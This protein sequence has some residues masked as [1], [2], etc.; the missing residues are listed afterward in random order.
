MANSS[1]I[2]YPTIDIKNEN[3]LRTAVLF[4]DSIRTIV[5]EGISRPYY[6]RFANELHNEGAL[7]PIVV[8]SNMDEVNAITDDIL[9]Y[10][11]DPA[12]APVLFGQSNASLGP[13]KMPQDIA[14]IVNIHPE[15]LPYLIR[16][17]FEAC[18]KR[19]LNDF[20]PVDHGF[21]SFYMTLLAKQL[22]ERLGLGL[23]TDSRQADKLIAVARR[24]CV[25]P[26]NV[27][28]NSRRIGRYYEA[29]GPRCDV[30][31][32]IAAGTV[33]DLMIGGIELPQKV[34]AKELIR[35]RK[36]HVEE[37]AALRQG[38]VQL[39]SDLPEEQSTEAF[40]QTVHDKY[41]HAVRPAIKS[42]RASLRA[43]GWEAATSGFLKAS[44]LSAA[45]T[46][47]LAALHVPTSIALLAGAGLSLTATAVSLVADRRKALEASP[48]SYLLSIEKEW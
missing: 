46:S 2:Y 10:L 36:S 14:E 20:F 34:T 8:E 3:W 33:L 48:Y 44:F 28:R 42:L 27:V 23:V 18:L 4:W 15:K 11:T 29:Y 32:E 1:V 12:S 39:V 47:A 5:P 9:D 25:L 13:D 30:P 21:A 40:R 45:P 24:G 19:S 7:D 31:K 43:Q 41:E 22:A 35:F 37:L 17:H 26:K 6:S 38:V 16:S